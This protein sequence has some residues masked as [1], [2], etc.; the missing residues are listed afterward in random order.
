MQGFDI[1]KLH[2]LDHQGV[3]VEAELQSA[4]SQVLT[5]ES[6]PKQFIK[7]CLVHIFQDRLNRTKNTSRVNALALHLRQASEATTNSDF[8]ASGIS[9]PG[10][11]SPGRP[12]NLG[13]AAQPK[14]SR[15]S[16]H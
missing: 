12:N 5:A 10:L 6:H 16:S 4:L 2:E 9:S 8:D 7:E 13:A 15:Y 1:V 3:I 11:P 14:I